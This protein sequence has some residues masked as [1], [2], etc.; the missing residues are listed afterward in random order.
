MLVHKVVG[1]YFTH[2][3]FILKNIAAGTAVR[4]EPGE[5]KSVDLVEIAGNKYNTVNQIKIMFS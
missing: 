4:F 2:L 5:D 1:K 3:Y